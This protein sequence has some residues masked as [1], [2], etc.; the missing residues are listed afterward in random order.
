MGYNPDI[1]HAKREAKKHARNT[2]S[3]YQAALEHIAQK[4][5]FDGWS[6]FLASP[7][8]ISQ[9]IEAAASIHPH[10]EKVT[11][12]DKVDKDITK[13]GRNRIW[14]VTI[15]VLMLVAVSWASWQTWELG[16]QARGVNAIYN[17][18]RMIAPK[19]AIPEITTKRDA[20]VAAWRIQGN[21]RKLYLTYFDWR[22]VRYSFY[23]KQ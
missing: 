6:S 15:I 8:P 16:E 12:V 17:D 20:Y 2:G 7:R 10:Q 5:G 23:P 1:A 21:R 3:S 11:A 9:K 18:E 13:S 14:F 22:T 19:V 4:A